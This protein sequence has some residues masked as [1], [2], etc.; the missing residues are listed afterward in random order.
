MC[1]MRIFITIHD[2][3]APA[4]APWALTS[5]GRGH[6]S[7][8]VL[9]SCSRCPPVFTLVGGA[10]KIH[11]PLLFGR[12]LLGRLTSP[13]EGLINTQ[14]VRA[15]SGTKSLWSRVVKTNNQHDYFNHLVGNCPHIRVANYLSAGTR[16]PTSGTV[17]ED[18]I[19]GIGRLNI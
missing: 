16:I 14:A 12:T 1:L 17:Y 18:E 5:V 19:I 2:A 6:K 7:L 10:I 8:R 4:Q 13:W 11:N 3:H 15:E 9:V